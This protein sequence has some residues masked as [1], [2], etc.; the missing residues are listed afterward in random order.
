MQYIQEILE[1]E[2][3]PDKILL[4]EKNEK[5]FFQLLNISLKSK[6]KDIKEIFFKFYDELKAY[7]E[8]IHERIQHY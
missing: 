4:D 8:E 3:Q 2:E 6:D 1:N 7:E 5:K